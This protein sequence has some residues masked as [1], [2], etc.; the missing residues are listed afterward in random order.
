MPVSEATPGR[1][2]RVAIALHWIV[3]AFALAQFT[4]GWWMQEIPKQPVGPRVDAYNLHKSTG[5]LIFAL[6]AARLGWRLAHP[7]PA[8]PPLPPWEARLARS[9]HALLYVALFVMPVTGYLGSVFSGYPVRA[10]GMVLPA[11]GWS[12]PAIKD[13]MSA[14]HLATSFV[15]ATLVL[16]HVAGAVRHLA[17][18][19]GIVRRMGPAAWRGPG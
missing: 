15:L 16:A 3:A 9:V 6:M 8:L 10:F 12:D 14:I 17:D 13:W 18:G 7:P 1:Y 5:L 19:S 11:W 2:H 4:W